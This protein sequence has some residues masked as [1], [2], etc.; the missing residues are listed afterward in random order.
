MWFTGVVGGEGEGGTQGSAHNDLFGEVMGEGVGGMQG[1]AHSEVIVGE[2][3]PGVVGGEVVEEGVIVVVIVVVGEG[4]GGM[5]G[6]AHREEGF[7]GEQGGFVVVVVVVVGT[8][9][10]VAIVVGAEVADAASAAPSDILVFVLPGAWSQN[11]SAPVP[12]QRPRL[13]AGTD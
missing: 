3:V 8:G 1:C 5:H 11:L 7:V 6:S 4:V 2:L 9:W 12:T 10:F 13:L